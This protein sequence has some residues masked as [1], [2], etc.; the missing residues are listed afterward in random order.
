MRFET[1]PRRSQFGIIFK[2]EQRKFDGNESRHGI[3]ARAVPSSCSCYPRDTS[4]KN[5]IALPARSSET[6]AFCALIGTRTQT[7]RPVD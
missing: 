3:V 4:P 7:P 2:R 6:D 1:D 5:D